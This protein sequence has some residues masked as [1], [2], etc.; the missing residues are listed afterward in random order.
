MSAHAA[1]CRC[2]RLA[3]AHSSAEG[4]RR[5]PAYAHTLLEQRIPPIGMHATQLRSSAYA[6]E[7]QIPE[8]MH[9]IQLD[10]ILFT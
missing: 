9:T 3:T 1:A 10:C 5:N 4:G 2:T 7:I 8:L 6:N